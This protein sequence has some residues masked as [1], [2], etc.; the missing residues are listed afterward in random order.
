MTSPH[1]SLQQGWT[2]IRFSREGRWLPRSRC[3]SRRRDHARL[4]TLR[5]SVVLS[6][7]RGVGDEGGTSQQVHSSV[8]VEQEMH[9]WRNA[10]AGGRAARE[11]RE[12]GAAFVV[13]E[14]RSR[15]G[16]LCAASSSVASPS[17]LLSSPLSPLSSPLV[18]S[19]SSPVRCFP[20]LQLLRSP[21]LLPLLALHL[22]HP[23]ATA[24]VLLSFLVTLLSSAAAAAAAARRSLSLLLLPSRSSAY[25]QWSG[26]HAQYC[27][28][29]SLCSTTS[30]TGSPSFSTLVHPA[31]YHADRHPTAHAR[32]YIAVQRSSRCISPLPRLPR[33]PPPS[34]PFAHVQNTRRTGRRLAV[35]SAPPRV[36]L[37]TPHPS[38]PHLPTAGCHGRRGEQCGA[39]PGV[40]AQCGLARLPA[41][42]GCAAHSS[43]LLHDHG[44]GEA[45]EV[46]DDTGH[47]Q[48]H[49]HTTALP[50]PSHTFTSIVPSSPAH[51]LLSTLSCLRVS[52]VYGAVS[53]SAGSGGLQV[54]RAL[55]LCARRGG[56]ASLAQ[57]RGLRA[58]HLPDQ[59]LCG[60]AVQV[61]AQHGGVAVP[62]GRQTAPPTHSSS[63]SHASSHLHLG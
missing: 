45:E 33:L 13:V 11:R 28:S 58:R 62:P 29:A 61:R 54:R 19:P 20:Q 25:E 57:L 41:L 63:I 44:R 39:R 50:S 7:V 23:L 46:Q 56:A 5:P 4:L 36:F 37:L 60:Q 59:G 15:L 38:P 8:P 1:R 26:V 27:A 53:A 34:P 2:M 17:Q 35:L 30:A 16:L 10:N 21:S 32:G 14:L 31:L 6:F 47:T 22:Q 9:L 40:F 55:R 24:T 51:L 48:A 49:H 12:E 43:S 42:V 3:E 18:S 52:S